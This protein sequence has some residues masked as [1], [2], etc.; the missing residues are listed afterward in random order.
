MAFCLR[1]RRADHLNHTAGV[2]H[3]IPRQPRASTHGFP[4]SCP[5]TAPEMLS[6][7]GLSLKLSGLSTMPSVQDAHRR[8]TPKGTIPF[9]K[10][11]ILLDQAS[12][13]VKKTK[14]RNGTARNDQ[15]SVQWNSGCN[16]QGKIQGEE[17]TF[18]Y[19]KLGKKT[20]L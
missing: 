2:L 19:E 11:V 3:T 17:K 10:S 16:D 20:P 5:L 7:E 1:S 8:M 15:N 6:V 18:I 4:A 9:P 12:P 14:V 13:F